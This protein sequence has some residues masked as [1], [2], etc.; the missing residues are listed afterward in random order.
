MKLPKMMARKRVM[1]M[2][3]HEGGEEIRQI[4]FD[5]DE[6]VDADELTPEEAAFMEGY[7]RD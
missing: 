2:L 6:W 7:E 3:R 5:I 1:R 4:F